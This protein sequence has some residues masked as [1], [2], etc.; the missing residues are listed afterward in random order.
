MN[1]PQIKSRDSESEKLV[2]LDISSLLAAVPE[3][4]AFSALP[5]PEKRSW[6]TEK[7]RFRFRAKDFLE[8]MVPDC[9]D[10]QLE[11]IRKVWSSNVIPKLLDYRIFQGARLVY[12]LTE[13]FTLKT[14][15]ELGD[16]LWSTPA[17]ILVYRDREHFI[18]LVRDYLAAG[19]GQR[20]RYAVM[21][22]GDYRY[23]FPGHFIW[24]STDNP[25]FAHP[26]Q[27]QYYVDYPPLTHRLCRML[28][29]QR[30]YYEGIRVSDA[31]IDSEAEIP[32]YKVIFLDIDGV[33]NDD[34]DARSHGVIIDPDMVRNLRYIVRETGAEIILSSSWRGV[35]YR[36]V[37]FG[38]I[39]GEQN[40]PLLLAA[41]EREGLTISGI[42]PL[43]RE[44]GA[45]ARPYEIRKWL[46]KYHTIGSYVILDDESFWNWGFLQGNVVT[47]CTR[48]PHKKNWLGK[49]VK[50][51]GLTREHAEQAIA[52]LER[53]GY[54]QQ[55]YNYEL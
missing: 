36:H 15:P 19:D 1:V 2:F 18:S 50:K 23:D 51:Y 20:V 6:I 53:P 29:A 14:L 54:R 33:L 9:N 40:L 44:S 24:M 27:I 30:E 31:S 49:T 4:A 41:F 55:F 37:K 25:E 39:P 26:E 43:S 38:P 16:G 5:L 10:M 46:M 48:Y 32:F 35:Y 17:D 12:L 3:E 52:I 8:K 11:Y 13:P 7:F 34:G 22:T 21:S 42:T 28:H 47:T 45:G